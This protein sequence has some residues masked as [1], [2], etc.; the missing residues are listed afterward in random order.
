MSA[1]LVL[2]CVAVLVGF[3]ASQNRFMSQEE[4][5]ELPEC[6]DELLEARDRSRVSEAAFVWYCPRAPLNPIVA[7]SC[8]AGSC[9][10][11]TY[12]IG[13]VVMP[14]GNC[15][16][17]VSY[18]NYR[19]RVF[20]C[21]PWEVDPDLSTWSTPPI[22]TTFSADVSYDDDTFLGREKTGMW[23]L[24]SQFPSFKPVRQWFES[25]YKDQSA[26]V[27]RCAKSTTGISF[28]GAACWH[29]DGEVVALKP[30][31]KF[32]F[33]KMTSESDREF[34]GLSSTKGSDVS[35]SK[36]EIW[37]NVKPENV[38]RE[39]MRCKF[40][41]EKVEQNL[42][43]LS[44]R[45]LFARELEWKFKDIDFY[46]YR[47]ASTSTPCPDAVT[48]ACVDN[49]FSF[50]AKECAWVRQTNPGSVKKPVLLRDM[51]S[52]VA[53]VDSA[54]FSSYAADSHYVLNLGQRNIIAWVDN[55]QWSGDP[56]RIDPTTASLYFSEKPNYSCSGCG[57]AGQALAADA[58]ADTC[59]V[60]LKCVTCEPWQRVDTPWRSSW[61]KCE[62][63]WPIRK[64]VECAAHHVRSTSQE[65]LADEK[66]VPCPALTPMRRE[67]QTTCA[68][69]EHTQWF[70]ASTKDGCLYFMSVADGLS[71]AGV[72]RFESSYVDQYK[73]V[74]STQRPEAVPALYYRNL[75]SDGNAWTT[76]TS[77]EMCPP[78]SFGVVSAPGTSV[79]RNVYG[80]RMQFRRWCGHAE[81]LKADDALLLPLNCGSRRPANTT[82]LAELVAGSGGRYSL[83][84]ERR[85]VANRMAEVKLTLTDG[86]SCF[87]ELRRE[88]RA[89]DCRFCT[90]TTYTQGCGPTYYA[91]LDAPAVAVAGPGTCTACEEQCSIQQF[92]NH[93]FAVTQFSCWSNG[94]ERVRGGE[95]GSL[96]LI[97]PMM[98]AS[99]NYWYKPA[100]CAPCAGVS[101]AAVPQ[102][103][104]RCGNKAVFETWHPAD[105]L[106]DEA[107]VN[108]PISQFCCALDKAKNTSTICVPQKDDLRLT[109]PNTLCEPNVP[110]LATS[111]A[112]FCPPKW[113]LDRSAP[114]CGG[115][116]TAW[117][118]TCCKQCELCAGA[119][120]IQTDKYKECSG[121]T[122]YD[123]QLAGCVTTCA[124]KNYLLDG[125]CLACETCA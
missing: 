98:S 100:A 92:P 86:F 79:A 45:R 83:V 54:S 16:Q 125:K 114:G 23:H 4:I 57:N 110:D 11:N 95:L 96:K 103:V 32:K 44:R 113:F 112:N 118:R 18:A 13:S 115:V 77:A 10:S 46:D 51:L 65:A 56:R 6:D 25:A 89:E 108:R 123:T 52:F 61:S 80:R 66:C 93:F 74:G 36:D 31:Y 2:V 124:E 48:E 62:P 49:A 71:F 97:R 64:C 106:P 50:F 94:T 15:G 75:V 67:G 72:R 122:D 116:L 70:D 26:R 111:Y 27:S 121:G 81:I 87:Y 42:D 1:R 69:C 73:P 19:R 63:S 84:K 39:F 104:T 12:Q 78:S 88:G 20:Q 38:D 59:G 29:D 41:V 21:M 99:M 33:T 53:P 7:Y 17:L 90:G 68:A 60:P 47:L 85:L 109:F 43:G 91:E 22:R 101:D 107:N 119:G 40:S 37:Y 24:R 120:K 30:W 3:A 14:M 76:S 82:S 28:T 105:N 55:V 5:Q 117:K 8:R 35:Y 34:C 9:V 58:N 102:I